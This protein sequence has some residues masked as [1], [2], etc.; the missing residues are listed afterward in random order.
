[1]FKQPYLRLGYIPTDHMAAD[2]FT[3]FYPKRKHA[4]WTKMRLNINVFSD[5]ESTVRVGASGK[6]WRNA[7]DYPGRYKPREDYVLPGPPNDN[8][9]ESSDENDQTNYANPTT[10]THN[11]TERSPSHDTTR[12]ENQTLPQL[13]PNR[14]RSVIGPISVG[15]DF[16]GLDTPI[17]CLE[18]LGV[19]FTHTFSSEINPH[20]RELIQINSPNAIIHE[21]AI[22]RGTGTTPSVDL[23]ITGPP[24]QPHSAAGLQQA[25]EDPR[26]DALKRQSN[27][28]Q[29]SCPKRSSSK[30]WSDS[31]TPMAGRQKPS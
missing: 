27:T 7:S 12:G 22:P 5:E 1:M 10:S 13:S 31:C 3:K 23:Y 11:T 29:P 9:D 17:Y 14:D 8:P 4:D 2:I 20:A 24:C 19:P 21:D 25:L 28:S 15:T 18:R 16:S 6:G 30:T 26:A